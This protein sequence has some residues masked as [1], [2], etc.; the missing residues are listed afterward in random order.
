MKREFLQNIKACDRSFPEEVIDSI[1]NE[2]RTFQLERP[3]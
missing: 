1:L 3:C 2:A